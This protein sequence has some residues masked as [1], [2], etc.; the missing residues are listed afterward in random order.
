MYYNTKASGARIR[1]LRIAKNFPLKTLATPSSAKLSPTKVGAVVDLASIP[2]HPRLQ[3]LPN[4]DKWQHQLNGGDDYQLCFT[5]SEQNFVKFNQQF[6]DKIF[7]IGKIVTENGLRLTY[8][9]QPIEFS[10][11]GYQHF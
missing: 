1:E 3:A 8:N 11:T 10:I 4:A 7:A 2:M 5:M 9:N 6:S